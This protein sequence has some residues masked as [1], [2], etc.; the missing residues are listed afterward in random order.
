MPKDPTTTDPYA[1]PPMH[2][3]RSGGVVRVAILAVM[4]GAAGLGYAWLS[5][6]ETTPLVPVAEDQQMADA[7]YDVAPTPPPAAA[8]EV[9]SPTPTP[10]PVQRRSA[11]VERAPAPAPEPEPTPAPAAITPAPAA[12]TPLPPMDVPPST[13]MQGE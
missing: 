3:D 7:G 1:A 9:A 8:P 13:G 5:G 11:P 6:Q 12:P 4:L 2:H 10:A